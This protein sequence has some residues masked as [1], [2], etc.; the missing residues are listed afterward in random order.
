MNNDTETKTED[1][2]THTVEEVA[3]HARHGCGRC[4]G[5]GYVVVARNA[6]HERTKEGTT[7][8]HPATPRTM[9]ACDCA[10]KRFLRRTK[11]PGVF[12]GIAPA[13]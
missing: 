1:K 9:T 8:F 11:R 4:G 12:T 5:Q 3:A 2:R 6:W 10:M 7:V 13:E